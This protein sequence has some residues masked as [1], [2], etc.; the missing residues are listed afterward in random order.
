MIRNWIRALNPADWISLFRIFSFPFILLVLVYQ[1]RIVFAVL[2]TLN[3][4]S[5]LLD[6]M[7]ARWLKCQTSRGATLDSI[8]DLLT[9][10]LIIIG[11][12]FFERKF[13]IEQVVIIGSTV[14]L[15]VLVLIS[16]FIRYRKP[17]SF[18]TYLSKFAA[19]LLG[20]F[21][22]MLFF[23]KVYKP[24]F[25]CTMIITMLSLLEEFILILMIREWTS[26]VKGILWVKKSNQF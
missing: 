14:L 24:F 4:I 13:F 26:N 9:V 11:T 6:G 21:F 3:L 19:L 18:H 2:I 20:V 8:G 12:Y 1:F 5:D 23:L 7:V 15:F 22:I 25:Y 10:S 16:G 17:G